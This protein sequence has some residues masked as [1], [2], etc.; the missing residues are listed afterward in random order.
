MAGISETRR[1]LIVGVN[2]QFGQIFAR[3]LGGEGDE[4]AGMDLQERPFD[5]GAC[6]MYRQMALGLEEPAEAASVMGWADCVLLCLPEDVIRDAL[7][8]VCQAMRRDALLVDIASVKTRIRDKFEAIDTQ[9]GYLS[10]HPMFGPME[11]FGGRTVCVVPLKASRR[12]ERFLEKIASWGADI[13]VMSADE[14]DAVTALVQAL[15]HAALIAFGAVLATSPVP[16][17]TVWAVATPIQKLM[18]ALAA[19]VATSGDHSTSWSIQSANPAASA[20][21]ESLKAQIERV[22]SVVAV[23]QREGFTAILD[24]IRSY[25]GPELAQLVALAKDAV[26]TKRS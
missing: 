23:Q 14:H 13:R 9:M 15:P 19:R 20:A 8:K 26:G 2:G 4:V 17:D 25:L 24:A 1:Y 10:I 7:P 21:R 18:L 6:P 5:A 22:E 16:L 3:K 12:G 11:D